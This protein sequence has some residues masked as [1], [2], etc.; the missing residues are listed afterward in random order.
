MKL[1]PIN[2]RIIIQRD[3]QPNKIG[4]I[5]I[6]DT[7]KKDKTTFGIVLAVD[8]G[9][10]NPQVKIGDRVAFSHHGGIDY[11][12]EDGESYLFMSHE[13]VKAVCGH[14]CDTCG[15]ETLVNYLGK[16][17]CREHFANA[18]DGSVSGFQIY[19]IAS[20]AKGHK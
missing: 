2:N 19:G 18:Y 3:E 12:H 15:E 8:A 7:A 17:L 20:K 4:S 5:Y 11:E 13:D 6:P 1:I 16:W 14:S 9:I 10:E